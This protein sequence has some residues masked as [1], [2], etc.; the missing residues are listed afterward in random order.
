MWTVLWS[1]TTALS[2]RTGRRIPSWS[3]E[4]GQLNIRQENPWQTQKTK[5]RPR[6]KIEGAVLPYG[7]RGIDLATDIRTSILAPV[8]PGWRAILYLS[9]PFCAGL[10]WASSRRSRRYPH[11]GSDPASQIQWSRISKGHSVEIHVKVGDTGKKDQLLLQ[12][13][14]TRFSSSFKQTAPNIYPAS[15]SA[16][17]RRTSGTPFKVPGCAEGNARSRG[18]RAGAL[19]HAEEL[20]SSLEIKQQQINQRPGTQGAQ[21]QTGELSRPTPSFSRNSSNQALVA[22]GVSEMIFV[23]RDRRARCRGDRNDEQA[24]PGAVEDRREQYCA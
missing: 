10:Y 23:S 11:Q 20:R 3:V 1:S 4:A 13:D 8:S 17:C 21:C 16:A 22:R 6:R 2:S 24:I 15:Q 9:D 12:I 18:T 5:R 14:Q 7:D 19:P